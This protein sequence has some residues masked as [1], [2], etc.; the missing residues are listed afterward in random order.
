M[1]LSVARTIL[2]QLFCCLLLLAPAGVR[3]ET[4]L[5]YAGA[6]TLQ[7]DFMPEAARLFEKET[8]ISFV[9]AGGNTNPGLK[10]LRNGAVDI[11]GS[12][13]FLTAEEKAA[14]LVETLIGWDPL[15]VVVHASN[16]VV[17][18]TPEQVRRLVSGE[19]LN[20]R[21]VGGRDLPVLQVATPPG[22]GMAD[23]VVQL[24]LGGGKI[25]PRAITS[26]IVAEADRQVTQLPAAFTVLSRSMVDAPDTKVVTISGQL[27]DGE[28]AAEIKR[29]P[30]IKPLLLVTRGKPAGP[31]AEFVDFS[32]SRA[33]QE[34]LGKKFIPLKS[35]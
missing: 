35:E 9:I 12:G 25:S 2:P 8:G 17:N 3:A 11:A 23:A 27:P 32:R 1:T 22:S 33:G 21:E 7:H 18:L 15:V 26:M 28:T 20:W 4:P 6:T 5:R 31:V 34:I 29:Y 24:V 14:G 13:R 16:P 10:A 19:I 30:Y